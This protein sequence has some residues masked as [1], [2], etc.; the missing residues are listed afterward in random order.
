MDNLWSKTKEEE[1]EEIEI[2]QKNA[3]E[4]GE[5][6]GKKHDAKKEKAEVYIWSLADKK[7][8]RGELL[9]CLPGGRPAFD[10]F[11]GVTSFGVLGSENEAVLVVAGVWWGQEIHFV[12][13]VKIKHTQTMYGKIYHK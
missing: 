1:E 2:K 9:C 4:F 11:A 13:Q 3:T 12:I 10:F 5:E 6:S 7:Q 8:S